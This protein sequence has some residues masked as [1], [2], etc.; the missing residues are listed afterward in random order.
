MPVGTCA[1]RRLL[2]VLRDLKGGLAEKEGHTALRWLV[3]SG[4]NAAE[5]FFEG[6][7]RHFFIPHSLYHRPR[8][9]RFL[10]ITG[11]PDFFVFSL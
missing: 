1:H 4:S 9:Q 3:I 5:F 6:V 7:F 2:R 10:A 11:E 8:N